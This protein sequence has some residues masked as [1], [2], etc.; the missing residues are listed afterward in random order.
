[1]NKQNS[2]QNMIQEVEKIIF[3]LKEKGNTR[4]VRHFENKLK[5]LKNGS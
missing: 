5:K 4:I 3:S 1:M 2:N